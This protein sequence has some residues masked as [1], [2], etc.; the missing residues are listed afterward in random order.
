MN[1]AISQSTEKKYPAG[2]FAV[3]SLHFDSVRAPHGIG[4]YLQS[5]EAKALIGSI[6]TAAGVHP[7][8]IALASVQPSAQAVG[9]ET[10][11]VLPVERGYAYCATRIRVTSIVPYSGER[12]SVINV[13]VNPTE[14][15]M[16]TWTPVRH[17]GEGNSWAEGDVQVYGIKPEYLNE[18]VANGVCK[19]V[20]SHIG[21]LSCQGSDCTGITHGNPQNAG[22]Q[23]PSLENGW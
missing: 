3:S 21:I 12:A 5:R 10:H 11:Y 6:A 20:T 2:L 18:F 7:L 17:Y 4:W 23:V 19:N 14:L 22:N 8:Y 1:M 16:T 15:Q 9:E 13:A